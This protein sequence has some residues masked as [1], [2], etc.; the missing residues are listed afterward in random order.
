MSEQFEHNDPL[1]PGP[2]EQGVAALVSKMQK[3]LVSLERKI[4]LLI[5]QSSGRPSVGARFSRPFRSFDRPHRPSDRRDDNAGGGER[6][7]DRGR[8]FK[9][10]Y[11]E[12]SRGFAYKKKDSGES[13]ESNFGQDR[14][15]TRRDEG[16]NQG[17]EQKKK[18]FHYK[19]KVRS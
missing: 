16:Q 4:D 14:Q 9:K 19:Q 17:F 13:R 3:Q 2:D 6:G 8:H 11:T 5:N 15:F 12:E 1:S 18:P 7:F 10:R